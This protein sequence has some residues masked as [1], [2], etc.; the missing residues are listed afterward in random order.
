MK[1]VVIKLS[2]LV[3]LLLAGIFCFYSSNS[4]SSDSPHLD[5]V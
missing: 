2:V 1:K 4:W 3:I 5:G